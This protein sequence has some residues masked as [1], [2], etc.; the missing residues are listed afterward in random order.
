MFKR[1]PTESLLPHRER[2][3]K[4][5]RVY[6]A[7]ASH[8]LASTARPG[9]SGRHWEWLV[10]AR[11]AYANYTEAICHE[12]FELIKSL[13]KANTITSANV[14]TQVPPPRH[15]SFTAESGSRHAAP[16]IAGSLLFSLRLALMLLAI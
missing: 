15:A 1:I 13:H 10:L 6:P 7:R 2:A 9:Q 3:G 8:Y 5:H 4:A 12:K 11:C 14:A 16:P